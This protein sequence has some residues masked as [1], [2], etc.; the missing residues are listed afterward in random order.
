M[1]NGRGEE[2]SNQM[3][4]TINQPAGCQAAGRQAGK[5][6]VIEGSKATRADN[7]TRGSYS[8]HV[9]SCLAR[10]A[11]SGYIDVGL[12]STDQFAGPKSQIAIWLH[13]WLT[14]TWPWSPS[15]IIVIIAI[16]FPES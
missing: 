9:L 10:S 13:T 16:S 7:Y 1:R 3:A 11:R 5:S 15:L 6:I 2:T 8:C 14:I 12:Y 4:E